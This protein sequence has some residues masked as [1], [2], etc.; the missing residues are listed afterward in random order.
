MKIQRLFPKTFTT[1]AIKT[2][3]TDDNGGKD[4]L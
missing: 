1:E 4:L 3:N 2:R